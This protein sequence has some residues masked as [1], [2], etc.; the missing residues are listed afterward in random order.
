MTTTVAEDEFYRA[1]RVRAHVVL[2][3]FVARAL[4]HSWGSSFDREKVRALRVSADE[5]WLLPGGQEWHVLLEEEPDEWHLIISETPYER[6]RWVYVVSGPTHRVDLLDLYVR[7]D[8]HDRALMSLVRAV[9]WHCIAV[10][11]A[12]A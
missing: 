10:S 11:G 4:K 1:E 6:E 9:G 12:A 3:S 8:P 7:D 2:D 5:S